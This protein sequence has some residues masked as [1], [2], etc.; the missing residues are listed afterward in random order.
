MHVI[1]WQELFNLSL[2]VLCTCN[3]PAFYWLEQ[4]LKKYVF[5]TRENKLPQVMWLSVWGKTNHRR[6]CEFLY[7]GQHTCFVTVCT[8]WYIR[9]L[10]C[11][12]LW[13]EKFNANSVT[14][15][16][17]DNNCHRFCDCL[18]KGKLIASGSVTVCMKD[19]E[20]IVACSVTVCM[21][22]NNCCRFC[23]CLHKG[24]HLPQVL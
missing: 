19:R 8:R 20:K 9:L 15:C 1:C 17:R 14:V 23:D 24:K 3:P 11:E 6:L 16:T 10:F 22:E 4:N 7:E 21:R 12:C 5:N 18:Y 2:C 13:G